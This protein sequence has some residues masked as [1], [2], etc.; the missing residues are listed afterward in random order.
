MKRSGHSHLN[1]TVHCTR[2]DTAIF[3]HPRAQGVGFVESREIEPENQLQLDWPVNVVGIPVAEYR[4]PNPE[5][6]NSTLR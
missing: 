2:G 3:E 1:L 6:I 5:A 4:S